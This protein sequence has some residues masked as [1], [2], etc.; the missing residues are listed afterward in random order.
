MWKIKIPAGSKEPRVAVQSSS[1]AGNWT[2]D[3][4]AVLCPL[5]YTNCY[6][7][8]SLIVL[9][10]PLTLA[11]QQIA[12]SEQHRKCDFNQTPLGKM[13][14]VREE[15][16]AEMCAPQPRVWGVQGGLCL[17][18]RARGLFLEIWTNKLRKWNPLVG[19]SSGNQR[20]EW[21]GRA[22]TRGKIEPS[23]CCS[24]TWKM[25]SGASQVR[26]LHSLENE[27][28]LSPHN[29]RDWC[30]WEWRTSSSSANC[31]GCLSSQ[32]VGRDFHLFVTSPPPLS[33]CTHK[34]WEGK[35]ISI[36]SFI[37]HLFFEIQGKEHMEI[38]TAKNR[39]YTQNE[40]QRGAILKWVPLWVV[41]SQTMIWLK[42]N[43]LS[44]SEGPSS[45]ENTKLDHK[46]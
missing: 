8:M 45:S 11:L 16:G 29:K 42:F 1:R 4:Q 34:S 39:L 22:A 21:Q 7:E 12:C 43:Y 41:L 18:K 15:P 9:P 10:C 3:L 19:L 28:Q 13:N 37:R 14:V 2:S 26:N 33:N 44:C 17:W 5:S 32:C 30:L 31:K 35:K 38:S 20:R 25:Q 24:L 27:T 40:N 23:L 36:L 6:W 46:D